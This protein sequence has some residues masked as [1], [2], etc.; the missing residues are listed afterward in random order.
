M[1]IDSSFWRS[2][3]DNC[4]VL[5]LV[6]NFHVLDYRL[7]QRGKESQDKSP[8]GAVSLNCP[9]WSGVSDFSSFYG[10]RR[11]DKWQDVQDHRYSTG[12]FIIGHY[13]SRYLIISKRCYWRTRTSHQ[14]LWSALSKLRRPIRVFLTH[15]LRGSDWQH[16]SKLYCSIS[17]SSVLSLDKFPTR[18]SRSILNA[19]V[20]ALID[21]PVLISP[22][23]RAPRGLRH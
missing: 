1:E 17:L 14:L 11:L 10:N 16:I 13:R 3:A 8:R 7:R 22:G 18:T 6:W 20:F 23:V 21:S 5:S 19:G 12:F 4:K 2:F 15:C 9:S